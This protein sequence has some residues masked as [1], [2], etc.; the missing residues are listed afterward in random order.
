MADI[1]PKTRRAE[2]HAKSRHHFESKSVEKM[3]YNP[4]IWELL[5]KAYFQ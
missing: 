1:F 2:K 4:R 5:L 3:P